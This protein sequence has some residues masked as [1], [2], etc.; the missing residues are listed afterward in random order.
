MHLNLV[1][2]ID[3]AKGKT[4]TR[5]DSAPVPHSKAFNEEILERAS[6]KGSAKPNRAMQDMRLN[7]A[8][9]DCEWDSYFGGAEHFQN[10]SSQV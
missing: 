2:L 8:S 9:P 7:A 1:N 4:E 3:Q 10:T 6:R 5:Q